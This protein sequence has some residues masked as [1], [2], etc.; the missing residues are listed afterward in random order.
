MSLIRTFCVCAFLIV[1]SLSV[2]A[3]FP[4]KNCNMKSSAEILQETDGAKVQINVDGGDAPYNYIFYKE[5]G[6]LLSEDFKNNSLKGLE[7]GKYFCTVIDK[8]NC[9][10][11]IQIDIK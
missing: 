2:V 7:A 3:F 1:D 6:H 4:G 11:T 8:K 10:N 9:R 5:S